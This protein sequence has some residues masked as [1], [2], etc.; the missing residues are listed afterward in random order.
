MFYVLMY[1]LVKDWRYVFIIGVVLSALSG[2]IIII[3]YH[4]SLVRSLVNKDFDDHFTM[5]VPK[6][7]HFQKDVNE[8]TEDGIPNQQISYLSDSGNIGIIYSDSPVFSENSTAF[9]SQK[10]FQGMYPDLSKCYESHEGNLTIL[11]PVTTNE[12]YY[13]IVILSKG[14][15]H[16]VIIGDNL[17]TIKKMGHSLR[18][19]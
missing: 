13:P 15:E 2:I 14:N 11:E 3:F 6:G 17:S 4:D 5:K 18:F 9:F 10:M 12:Q 8:T 7:M 16:V 19:D 1:Y